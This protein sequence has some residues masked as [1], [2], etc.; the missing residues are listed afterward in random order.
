VEKYYQ[1][2][3]IEAEISKIIDNNNNSNYDA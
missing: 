2:S 3:S 1:I